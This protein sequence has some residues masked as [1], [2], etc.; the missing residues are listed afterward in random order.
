MGGLEARIL[1]VDLTG[2]TTSSETLRG[3]LLGSYVGG[4]GLGARLLYDL[5]PPGSDPLGPENV[6]M[7]LAGPLTGT[8][9][10][11]M[12]GCVVAQSP[13]TRTF[14]DSYHGGSF[15]QEIRYAGYYGL[16]VRGKASGPVCIVIEDGNV[17]LRDARG[18]WGMDT[19]ET[20][21]A[22]KAMLGDD[23]FKVACIG[24]AG[25]KRVRFAMVSCEYNRHAGRG[26][27]GAVMGS[28]FLKAVA[29]KGTQRVGSKRPRA[30]M[31]AVRQAWKEIAD[32]GYARAFRVDGT[33][34][35]VPYANAEGLLPSRNYQGG[36]F[37][38]ASGVDQEAQRK[39]IWL[40]DTAC[41]FCPIACGKVGVI[42]EGPGRGAVTDVVEYETAA[43]LGANLGISDIHRLA[44]AVRLCDGLG[45]DGMST[46]GVI[47]FAMEAQEKGLLPDALVKPGLAFGD[48]QGTLELIKDIAHRR[49]PLGD[50]LA[51]GVMRASEETALGELAVHVK[52]LECPA[53]GPRGA[54]GMGLALMTA[55]RGGCHQRAFPISYEVGGEEYRGKNLDRLSVEGKAA[56]VAGLQDYLAALDT[57]V[58][59]DFG[60][61]SVSEATY[62]AMLSAA[63]GQDWTGEDLIR[64]G[65]R[66]W[67]VTRL[68]NVANG[69]RREQDSLPRRFSAERL[70]DGPAQGHRITPEEQ[71]AMLDEYYEVRG[72]DSEGRPL[73]ATLD[74]LG[75]QRGG[76]A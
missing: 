49:T 51:E 40:R 72:W 61:Y 11:S 17:S 30:F 10:P 60:Q 56:L 43:M 54:P 55:D 73:E 23:S 35:S 6:L 8:V 46:G 41:A 31:E 28:K 2:G 20:N 58:K 52:G 4:K 26:G 22:V 65:E 1:Q 15:A 50:L 33:P 67:N 9:A 71:G 57:L 34:G 3:D 29:I 68:F 62:R 16:L 45:L 48:T 18:L 69:F 59:C 76:A 25:E 66:V 39:A 7:F 5:V 74:R 64:L 42:R 24:P 27:L 13:L 12:R 36:T 19:F 14:C 44:Y 53:W 38:G 32:S 63:T 70:P 75:I 37:P 21:S 47:G